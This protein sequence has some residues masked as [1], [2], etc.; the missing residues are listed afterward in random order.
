VHARFFSFFLVF[1]RSCSAVGDECAL[2]FVR[3]QLFG[4]FAVGFVDVFLVGGG[5]DFKEIWRIGV[6]SQRT[7]LIC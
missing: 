1:G 6:F 5:F 2:G 7:V 4:A 3:V